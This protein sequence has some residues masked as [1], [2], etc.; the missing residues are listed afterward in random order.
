MSIMNE[1]DALSYAYPISLRLAR[2]IVG[3]VFLSNDGR[4]EFHGHTEYSKNINGMIQE[5][6][7]KL[8]GK[9]AA[10]ST[11]FYFIECIWPSV[12]L[13]FGS[14]LKKSNPILVSGTGTCGKCEIKC[15]I[16]GDTV[17]AKRTTIADAQA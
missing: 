16:I 12:L 17:I 3:M 6:L 7:T 2:G 4:Y 10:W 5:Y 11:V 9:E 1:S 14:M 13:E 8:S 15:E